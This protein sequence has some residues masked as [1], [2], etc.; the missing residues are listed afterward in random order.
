MVFRAAKS[1]HLAFRS[2]WV[3]WLAVAALVVAAGG[4]KKGLSRALAVL[5]LLPQ[6]GLV[7][8][9]PACRGSGLRRST[10]FPHRRLLNPAQPVREGAPQG[11]RFGRGLSPQKKSLSRK[12]TPASGAAA[13]IPLNWPSVRF[14]SIPP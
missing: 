13:K 6:G 1:L 3:I 7:V 5:D 2:K 10:A 8:I 11:T 4:W 14:R 9:D 12:F